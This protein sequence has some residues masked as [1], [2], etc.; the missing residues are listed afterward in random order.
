LF[1]NKNYY[2]VIGRLESRPTKNI[3]NFK[4]SL[5]KYQKSILIKGIDPINIF[6]QNDINL[7][8]IEQSFNT[9]IVAR[10]EQIKL[11]GDDQKEIDDIEKIFNELIYLANRNGTTV[12]IRDVETVIRT[13]L[14]EQG[15][16]IKPKENNSAQV[17]LFTKDGFVKAKTKGQ[18]DYF[19]AV[20]ENDIVFV[21]GPAGT[22]K[23]Y[24]AVAMAVA[25]LR[26]KEVNKIVLARPAV[27]AGE[28]LGFLPGDLLEKVDPYLR[29]LYDAL[30]DMLPRDILKK[31]FEQEIIEVIPL[32]YMRGRTLNSAF[33]ILDEAQNASAIQMKM[34]LTRLG[35]NSRAIITGDITQIDLQDKKSSGLVQIQD[36]L[37]GIDGIKFI[38][39]DDRDVVRHH[40][41]RRII[42]A[43]SEYQNGNGSVKKEEG[44]KID[45]SS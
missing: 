1:I 18:E 41:V 20:S 39:L 16:H 36:I 11:E 35:I 23:T 10:G 22:G 31:Y 15:V 14:S 40:L 8:T 29:P 9:K 25:S 21:I 34:F 32:A 38:Y 13:S 4:L 28:S 44:G 24:M 26:N 19:R 33:V 30:S 45:E 17:I 5:G 27:E 3:K 6:G 37:K 2:L 43:Y 12:Q 42:Q 7:K